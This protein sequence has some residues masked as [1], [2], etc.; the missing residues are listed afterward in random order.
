[1]TADPGDNVV[2]ATR[3]A[4]GAALAVVTVAIVVGGPVIY[5]TRRYLAELTELA[6]R[7]P[8]AA[9]AGFRTWVLPQVLLMAL[10]GLAAGAWLVVAGLRARRTARFP[11]PGAWVLTDT[12]VRRGPEAERVG[13]VLI[14]AGTVMTMVPV[15][16]LAILAAIASR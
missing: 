8:A 9:L 13:L 10:V 5:F 16:L 4:R 11:Q 7:D 2:R 1:M 12:P 14:A 3:G 15:L 6:D